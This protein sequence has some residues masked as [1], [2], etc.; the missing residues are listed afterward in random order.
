[1]DTLKKLNVN[2]SLTLVSTNESKE[3]TKNTE[4]DGVRS[5]I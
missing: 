5:G 2:Q 3:K 1:M 4:N